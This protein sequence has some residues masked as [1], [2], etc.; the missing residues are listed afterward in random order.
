MQANSTSGLIHCFLLVENPRVLDDL[1]ALATFARVVSAGSMSAAA[2]ELDLSL[3]V[4]SKRLARL[5]TTL[6]ARLLQRTTRRKKLTDEGALFHAQVVKILAE[7][8]QAEALISQ[9]R[10][11]S[12][13]CCA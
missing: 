12:R 10:T 2:R 5:E 9:R 4:V 11:K 3:A 7:V 1:P 13:G 8:E 6:G